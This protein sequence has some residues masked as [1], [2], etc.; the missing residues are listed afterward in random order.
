MD[1]VL[2]KE[3]LATKVVGVELH[4]NDEYMDSKEDEANA[5]FS[6]GKAKF[7]LRDFLRP[8]CLELKLRS[9]VFPLKR[10][11]VDNSQNLDLNTTARKNENTVEKASPYLVCSTYSTIIANLSRPIG[12]FDEKA[13]I[14]E[15]KDMIKKQQEI[16]SGSE[17]ASPDA[18]AATD[19]DQPPSSPELSQKYKSTTAIGFIDLNE[20]IFE[21]MVIIIPY[22]SPDMVKRIEDSFEKVN[23]KGLNLPN[24]RYLS[25]KEFSEEERSDRKLDFMGGFCL[26]DSETRMY[27]FE[28]LGGETK[29]LH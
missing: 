3:H 4:D 19:K 28:G 11:L 8:N 21:R 12:P 26:M 22:K 23:L 16:A 2:L 6:M 14:Q 15:Y 29:G 20:A 5:K 7:T 13:E 27:I 9:D 24:A 18:G 17:R 25:T 1:H 10:D